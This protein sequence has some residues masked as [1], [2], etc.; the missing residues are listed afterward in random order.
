M[1]D[2]DGSGIEAAAVE[3]DLDLLV[4]KVDGGFIASAGE[5]EG[6]VFFDLP[7]LLGIEEFVAVFGGRQE[8]EADQVDAEA[9]DRFH[10]DGV[11]GRGVVFVLDPVSELSI[12]G[13]ER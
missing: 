1:V 8:A 10:A 5:A 3:A 4:A 12:E 13:V 11:V 9:V 2:D 7:V 6:V